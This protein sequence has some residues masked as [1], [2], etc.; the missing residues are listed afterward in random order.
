MMFRV[1]TKTPDT[2]TLMTPRK[3]KVKVTSFIW[4]N[5][6]YAVA[7]P[8]AHFRITYAAADELKPAEYL[9]AR[10]EMF[11]PEPFQKVH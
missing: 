9:A 2:S 11:S 6:R 1:H 4:K 7:L 10:F 3:T 8:R 5:E